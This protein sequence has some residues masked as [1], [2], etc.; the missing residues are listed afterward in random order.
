MLKNDSIFQNEIGI[1]NILNHQD[2]ERYNN[3]TGRH[4]SNFEKR[5]SAR[6]T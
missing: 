6:T 1:A 5:S 2:L 3:S 4:T